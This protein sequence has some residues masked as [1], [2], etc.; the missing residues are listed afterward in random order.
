[1]REKTQEAR[2][3]MPSMRAIAI[4]TLGELA[5]DPKTSISARHTVVKKLTQ[6]VASA[7]PDAAEAATQ[8]ALIQ[9]PKS[10]H[11]RF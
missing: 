11:R 2:Q 8:L 4:A 5:R 3:P 10:R 9:D 7:D 6:I 1:M